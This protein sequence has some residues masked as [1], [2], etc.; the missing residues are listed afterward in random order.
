MKPSYYE[1]TGNL[2]TANF[3]AVQDGVI[4][5]PDL[6]KVGVALDNGEILSLDAR[7]YLMNHTDRAATLSP[8]LTREAAQASVSD[9]LTVKK[10]NLCVIPSDGLTEDLCWEFSCEAS[11]GT[12][13]LVYVNAHTGVEE[14]LLI[15]LISEDGQL[16]V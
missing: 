13:V 16:T 15:L 3:V 9:V 8:T 4:L 7:G 10:A 12:Q 2:L 1:I 5:Y 6:I 14:Q 11:D